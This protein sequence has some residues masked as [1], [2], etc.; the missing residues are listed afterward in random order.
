MQHEHAHTDFDRGEF[1]HRI[2]GAEYDITDYAVY[3]L[4]FLI[5]A[6]IFFFGDVMRSFKNDPNMPD[7]FNLWFMIK[8]N[9]MRFFIVL[10]S[11]FIAIRFHKTLL[12]IDSLNEVNCLFH[13]ISF[14]AVFG[15]IA[16]QKFNQ[17]PA[18]KKTRAKEMTKLKRKRQ[19]H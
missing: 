3:G 11:I 18:V 13:G 7:R 8:D 19:N 1:F 12:G 16:A 2:L 9:A 5:G 14:D 17:I 15:K 10:I 6:G 4:F